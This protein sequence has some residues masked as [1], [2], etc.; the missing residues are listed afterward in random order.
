MSYFS[1]VQG[2]V[3]NPPTHKKIERDIDT[4]FSFFLL[5]SAFSYFQ[6]R[7]H[8]TTQDSFGNLLQLY[9]Y[10][11]NYELQFDLFFFSFYVTYVLPRATATHISGTA[12][13]YIINV[14]AFINSTVNGSKFLL[15]QL[16]SL[17]P[18]SSPTHY[19]YSR[20]SIDKQSEK[21]KIHNAPN[22]SLY[23]SLFPPT[24]Q[25]NITKT[26]TLKK[27]KQIK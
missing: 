9:F 18:P 22:S 10:Y 13:R 12:H 19:P 16:L 1:F 24:L 14:I 4:F 21:R 27:P 26:Q 11:H 15:I 3:I 25:K 23:L 17:L 20:P 8:Q 7:T 5:F 2:P 6:R